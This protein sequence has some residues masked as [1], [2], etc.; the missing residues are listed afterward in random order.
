ML[1][2]VSAEDI[3]SGTAWGHRMLRFRRKSLV[4]LQIPS[5]SAAKSQQSPKASRRCRYGTVHMGV[6]TYENHLSTAYCM[7]DGGSQILWKSAAD[8]LSQ[9]LHF[10]KGSRE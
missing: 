8:H 2:V 4:F 5:F 6:R 10:C 1:C 7:T 3:S 9:P